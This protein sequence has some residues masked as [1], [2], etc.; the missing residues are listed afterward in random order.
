MASGSPTSPAVAQQK[1]FAD[2]PI[3]ATG[4]RGAT[5]TTRHLAKNGLRSGLDF[6][7]MIEGFAIRTRE[8]NE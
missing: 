4:K 7:N 6:D 5:D 2:K 8:R 3:F 1:V